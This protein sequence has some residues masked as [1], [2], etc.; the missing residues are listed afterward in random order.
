MKF[1][2]FIKH[3]IEHKNKDAQLSLADFIE[4]HYAESDVKDANYDEDMKLP[5]KTHNACSGL[6]GV[7]FIP[8]HFA[9]FFTSP[10]R[11][12]ENSYSHYQEKFLASSYLS[13]IWQP[14]KSC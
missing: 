7:F 14:P 2:L 10:L 13:S 3:F 6:G 12:G 11:T 5:F 8:N 1:P 4:M 9:D